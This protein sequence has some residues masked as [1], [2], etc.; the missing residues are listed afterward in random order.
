ML[1]C[2]EIFSLFLIYIYR[3]VSMEF[4]KDLAFFVVCYRVLMNQKGW[5]KIKEMNDGEP[6]EENTNEDFCSV[7]GAEFVPDFSNV[8]IMEYFADCI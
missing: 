2:D 1:T 7:K 8:F 5:N 3:F 4:Y 6:L